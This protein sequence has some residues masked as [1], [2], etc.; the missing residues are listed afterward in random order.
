MTG[1]SLNIAW[2]AILILVTVASCIDLY[3][4]RIPNWLVLPFLLGGVTIQSITGGI[5]AAGA[6]FGGIALAALLFGVPCWLGAMGMG[7]LKLV[8][9][10]GAWIGPSQLVVA[11][12]ATGIAGGVMAVAYALWCKSFDRSLGS[13]SELLVD[14]ARFRR[15]PPAEVRRLRSLPGLSIPY[16]PAIALGTVF[17]FFA[18]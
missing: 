3:C 18:R 14:I 12:V 9:A 5:R 17:S 13:A 11:F 2:W 8:A 16:A 7:D 4:R 15:R 6:S 1:I 10:V